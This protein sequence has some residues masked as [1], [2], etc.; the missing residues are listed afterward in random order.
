MM[1]LYDPVW[2]RVVPARVCN[3]PRVEWPQ[4]CDIIAASE[5]TCARLLDLL[6]R[7]LLRSD[8]VEDSVADDE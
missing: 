7:L 5:A 3:L 8:R 6:G 1:G 4:C 2:K